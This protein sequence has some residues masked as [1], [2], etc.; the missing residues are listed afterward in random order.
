MTNIN[1]LKISQNGIRFIANWEG[2]RPNRY[3]CPAG[4]WTIGIGH[5]VKP[6]EVFKEPLSQKEIE[7]LF[8]QDI[9]GFEGAVNRL[10]K[11]KLTQNQFDALVSFTFNIGTGAFQHSTLLK[12]LNQGKHRDAAEQFGRW[13]FANGKPLLGLERRRVAEKNLFLT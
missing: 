11:V 8:R 1:N 2:S 12:I 9:R 10:V 3:K 5:L 6:G 7:D 4:L 13:T